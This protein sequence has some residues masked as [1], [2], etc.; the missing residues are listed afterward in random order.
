MFRFLN[1]LDGFE[2]MHKISFFAYLYF[3]L[4]PQVGFYSKNVSIPPHKK[5]SKILTFVRKI[6]I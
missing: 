6:I 3:G 1:R 4:G 5:C 2:G